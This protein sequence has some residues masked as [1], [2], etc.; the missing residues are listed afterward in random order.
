[1]GFALATR[2]DE[3]P[4]IAFADQQHAAIGIGDDRRHGLDG[5]IHR[6]TFV[7]VHRAILARARRPRLRD[8]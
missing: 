2:L 6:G 1:M 7:R 5:L 8:R 4:G 3:D